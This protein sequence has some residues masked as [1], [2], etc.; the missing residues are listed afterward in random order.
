MIIGYLEVLPLLVAACPSYGDSPHGV[1]ADDDDGEYLGVG[2]L[3]G[4]LI[5]LL[6][7]GDTAC[8]SGVFGVVE[9]VLEEGDD[10]AR[11]LIVDGFYDDLTSPAFYEGADVSPGDFEPWFGP[12]S[13]KV[14]AVRRLL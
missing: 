2:H 1:H 7:S 11:K 4:H 14:P 8:F 13:R 3:V 10:E 9:W 6:G 12:Q 5:R